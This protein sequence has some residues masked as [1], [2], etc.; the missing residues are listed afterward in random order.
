[1]TIVI[2]QKSAISS[3][4]MRRVM[5]MVPTSVAVVAGEPELT[6]ERVAM[7]V[8]S[9]VSVSLEP[10]LVGFFVGHEST[11]WPLLNQATVLGISALASEQTDLCRKLSKKEEDRFADEYWTTGGYGAPLIADAVARIECRIESVT[12]AGDHDFVLAR[13]LG[14][15]DGPA[16]DPLIFHNRGFSGLLG[17]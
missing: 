12:P 16:L 2:E 7:V 14:L 9:F 6:G 4:D 3:Q 17:R 11:S 5:G 10:C 1:M 8:G 15:S 13:V